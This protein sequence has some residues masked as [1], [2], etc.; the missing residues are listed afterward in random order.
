MKEV[1][2]LILVLCS[3]RDFH[4]QHT[5]YATDL[6]AVVSTAQVS[7][8]SIIEPARVR[9]ARVAEIQARVEQ[10]VEGLNLARKDCEKSIF[11]FQILYNTFQ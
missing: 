6:K 11:S 9:R 1:W 3:L 5:H 2:K 4:S 7:L 10:L 8:E